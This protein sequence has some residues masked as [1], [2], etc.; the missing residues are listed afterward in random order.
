MKCP[1]CEVGEIIAS[2]KEGYYCCSSCD[3]IYLNKVLDV[4]NTGKIRYRIET[5]RSKNYEP[6]AVIQKAQSKFDDNRFEVV[7]AV[8]DRGNSSLLFG[9]AYFVVLRKM[10]K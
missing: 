9:Q 6:P 7:G 2:K 3:A 10:P 1:F 8:L 5:I 4:V